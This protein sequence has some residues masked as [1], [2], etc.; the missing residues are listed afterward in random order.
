[1]TSQ[2]VTLKTAL[3]RFTQD[4]N[5]QI[6]YLR[7]SDRYD[8]PAEEPP[9][10]LDEKIEIVDALCCMELDLTRQLLAGILTSTG[11]SPSH[12]FDLVVPPREWWT[13]VKLDIAD[14]SAV[15]HGE[16]LAG[17]LI[18]SG[19][20]VALQRPGLP[21]EQGQDHRRTGTA[22]RPSSARL[23]LLQMQAR[24]QQG[25]LGRTKA[26]E[27]RSLIEWLKATHPAAP[28][29]KPK[30]LAQSPDLAAEYIRLRAGREL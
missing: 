3:W 18:Y 9:L 6:T 28:C 29:P 8:D 2:G 30:S 5:A 16:K 1:M 25:L 12:P 11:F 17:V 4:R 24:A 26:E 22:G 20:Q 19:P 13:D 23:C 10:S 14:N 15:V 27:A 7:L 21:T